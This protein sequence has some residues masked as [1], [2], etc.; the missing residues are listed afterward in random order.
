MAV[1]AKGL[2]VCFIP[3]QLPIPTMGYDVIHHG[4]GRELAFSLTLNAQRMLPKILLTGRTP[5]SVITSLIGSA[6]QSVSRQ[7]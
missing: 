3:E 7:R 5:A 1:L 2:P 4:G 6:T